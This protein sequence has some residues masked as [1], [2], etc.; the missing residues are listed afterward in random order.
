MNEYSLA[1]A[2]YD[3]VPVAFTALALVFIVRLV[4][5]CG[6]QGWALRL[7]WMGMALVTVAGLLKASWK[8]QMALFNYDAVWMASALFPLMAPGFALLAVA[9]WSGGRTARGRA[10]P[11]WV[12]A[13]TVCLIAAAFGLAALRVSQGVERG[14]FLPLI[15]LASLANLLLTA[16]LIGEAGRRGRWWLALL[17][18]V[19]LGM[20]FAL[21]QIAQIEPMT[22][23]LHWLEQT[24]TATGAGAFALA[25]FLLYR[26]LQ[27]ERSSD[28]TP[29]PA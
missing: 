9:F 3:F 12:W 10:A 17:F 27:T 18:C 19:N 28:A 24:L 14:W 6:L 5:L 1:L 29:A 23:A 2:L 7:S 26:E 25:C 11:V 20:V 15:S 22:I 13:C 16:L 4:G 8:L 21:Q